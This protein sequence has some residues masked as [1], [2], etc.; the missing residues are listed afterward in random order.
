VNTRDRIL[1]TSSEGGEMR[2]F[3]T[4]GTG[5]VG[6]AVVR[7]LLE[8]GHS[9]RALVRPGTNT[10]QLDGLPVERISGDLSNLTA[11][12]QGMTGCE[13]V[14]HVAALYAYWGYSWDEFYQT[15]VEGTRRVLEIA[16]QERA[17]RIIYTS[18]I[19]ALGIPDDGSPGNEETPVTVDDMIGSYKRSKFLAEQVALQFAQQGTPVVIVNPAAPVGVGDHKPTQTGKLIVDFLN[20]RMPAYVDTGLTIVDVEDVAKGHLLAAERGRIGE[21]YILGGENLTLKQVLDI[22]AE[23]SGRPPVRVRIPRLIAMLWAYVDTAL[24]RLNPRHIPSAT[25][26]A[27]R[28]SSKREYFSSAKAVRELGYQYIPA[29]QALG[30]AVDWYRANGYTNKGRKHP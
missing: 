24:A 30:K 9:V 20:G 14:F 12:H 10:R 13:W 7:C 26:D 15:N 29:R 19:A 23:V 17:E 22:L 16:R 8:A 18:S 3:V 6:G 28:V 4:G 11:L 2:V 5:F 1:A 21:R 25:P 27:V